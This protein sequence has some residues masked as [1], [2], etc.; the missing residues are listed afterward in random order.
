MATQR[1]TRFEIKYEL[2]SDTG[3]E[4][5]RKLRREG[6]IPAV[7]YSGGEPALHI[8]LDAGHL[9]DALHS[10]EKIFNIHINGERRRALIKDIQYH[11][12]T[13]KILHV[14]LQ[15][16]R[17]RDVVELP[18]PVVVE[19]TSVGV[20]EEGGM[21]QVLHHEIPIRCK[22]ADVPDHI[23][24]DVTNLHMGEAVHVSDLVTDKYEILLPEDTTILAVIHPQKMEAAAPKAVTEAEEAGETDEEE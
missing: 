14:D 10:G 1:Q 16:V 23:V 8:A 9:H 13:D 5:T 7:F 4:A 20:K 22:G 2:R 17:L 12:V 3:K 6:K 21:I 11:P 19:G 18:V 24:V 15:G